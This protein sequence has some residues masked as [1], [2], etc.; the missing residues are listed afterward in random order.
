MRDGAWGRGCARVAV[1]A[2]TFAHASGLPRRL[3]EAPPPGV[4]AERASRCV[5]LRWA[6]RERTLGCAG[7]D[8]GGCF[9]CVV[10]RVYRRLAT[11]P[12]ES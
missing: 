7:E 6:V 3:A 1:A 11:R 5:V 12:H 9:P 2:S 4:G 8:A 10:W